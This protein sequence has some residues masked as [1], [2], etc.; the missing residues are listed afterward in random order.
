VDSEELPRMEDLIA[1]FTAKTKEDGSPRY[2]LEEC[3][4]KAHSKIDKAV[5]K[6]QLRAR[7]V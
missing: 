7:G 3:I 4:I 5:K 2:T 6:L 1:K